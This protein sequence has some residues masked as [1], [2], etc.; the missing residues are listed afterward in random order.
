MTL[1]SRHF[2]AGLDLLCDAALAPT[3]PAAEVAKERDMLLNDLQQMRDDMYQYPLR[4]AFEAAFGAHPYGFGLPTVESAVRNVDASMLQS[5]HRARVLKSEPWFFIT[6]DVS[7]PDITAARVLHELQPVHF[8]GAMLPDRR[9]VW[10][11]TQQARAEQRSKQQ[12]AIALA[13]PGPD[14][15]DPDVDALRLLAS[16]VS[17]LGG[18]LFEELRSKRSLAYAISA[19]PMARWRAGAFVAYIGTSPQREAEARDGLIEQLGLLKTELLD[20]DEVERAKRYMIGAW[21]IRSQTNAAQLG[22]LANA[23]LFGDGLPEIRSF[24][25]RI[26]AITAEAMRDAA[27]KYLD[28]SRVVEGV[29]RGAVTNN[30][31]D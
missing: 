30:T 11:T 27:M 16:A 25:A 7:D 9:P 6:G 15:N 29:V 10:P 17:G 19:F 13:F 12:T 22:E 24:E 5:W 26:Q 18:R 3:F 20:A 2:D 28:T 1:P 4:L 21:K 8:D 31:Q 14:R 23:V